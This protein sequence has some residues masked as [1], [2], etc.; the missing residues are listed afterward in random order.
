MGYEL[1][2]QSSNLLRTL[3]PILTIIII[4]FVLVG[5]IANAFLMVSILRRKALR[6]S[7]TYL[8][9]LSLAG[10]DVFVLL[11]LPLYIYFIYTGG[12]HKALCQVFLYTSFASI[13][14]STYHLVAFA[15]MRF[16][17]LTKPLFA[18]KHVTAKCTI[19][20]C[21]V[22]WLLSLGVPTTSVVFTGL[23]TFNV[24]ENNTVG[25]CLVNFDARPFTMSLLVVMTILPILCMLLFHIV[26]AFR[27]KAIASPSV[28]G[29]HRRQ[30]SM[31]FIIGIL[32]VF[33]VSTLPSGVFWNL[34][35]LNKHS[36]SLKMVIIAYALTLLNYI[37]SAVNPLMYFFFSN[38]GKGTFCLCAK[39]EKD[40]SDWTQK[41]TDA[42]SAS[43]VSV[44]GSAQNSV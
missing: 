30:L 19:I 36:T 4:G 44:G 41:D 23:T 1:F 26:K 7:P 38:K 42:G 25:I 14:S 13:T 15:I 32:V 17:L 3:L 21:V 27:V 34:V 35:L 29:T 31:K 28:T 10:S 33:S 20:L 5:F 18:K 11:C 9:L 16:I 6:E 43:V 22:I 8:M 2:V 40:D 12:L 37:N 39:A 24:S